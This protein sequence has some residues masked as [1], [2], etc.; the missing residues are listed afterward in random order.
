M[1]SV[2]RHTA[3]KPDRVARRAFLILSFDVEVDQGA[4]APKIRLTADAQL[5]TI[6]DR[7]GN[8]VQPRTYDCGR[9]H[10]STGL[11]YIRTVLLCDRKDIPT[12]AMR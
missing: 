6:F 4:P 8:D 5:T 10:L 2:T 12:T 1:M 11:P 7:N 3:R 9:D